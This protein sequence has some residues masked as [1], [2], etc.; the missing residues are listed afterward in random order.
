MLRL[1]RYI[2]HEFDRNA[3]YFAQTH[4]RVA[5]SCDF[6]KYIL[7]DKNIIDLN[8]EEKEYISKIRE[9]Y[10]K[11][12]DLSEQIAQEIVKYKHFYQDFLLAD[13]SGYF[14]D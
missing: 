12:A 9:S 1:A 5:A 6:I 11:M 8:E 13:E 10:S 3:I 4:S 14:T 7:E 2:E